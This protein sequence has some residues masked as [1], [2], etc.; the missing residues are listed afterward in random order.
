MM[1]QI[2]EELTIKQVSSKKN[3]WNSKEEAA[4]LSD[5]MFFLNNILFFSFFE[6]KGV[7][8]FWG[9]GVLAPN[10]EPRSGISP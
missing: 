2:K 7:L 6:C 9:F 3:D 5:Y 1:K 10:R 8:G 4:F